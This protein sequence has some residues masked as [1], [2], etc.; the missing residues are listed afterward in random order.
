MTSRSVEQEHFAN[1]MFADQVT[2]YWLAP[3]FLV[4]L[5]LARFLG[6]ACPL[7]P[8]LALLFAF[9]LYNGVLVRL[10]KRRIRWLPDTLVYCTSLLL[11][12]AILAAAIHY[13]G[14]IESILV[15]LTA[16]IAIFSALFLTFAQCLFISLI[17]AASYVAVLAL[18][19]RGTLPHYH[20]FPALPPT[21]HMDG[22]YVVMVGLGVVSVLVTLGLMAGYLATGRRRHS[23]QMNRMHLRLEEWNRDLELRVEEKMRSLRAMH[24]QLQE[25]Y[26]GTVKAFMQALEAKDPYTRS[27]SQAV[28]A[29]AHLIGLELGFSE[30]RLQRLE[31][32][33]E[34]HDIGKIAVPD[35]ILL[36]AGPLTKE[37]FEVVKQHP[38]WGARILESLTFMKDVTE[39]VLQEHERW[40]GRGYP[41]G[42]KGEAIRLEARIIAVTDAW[43]AMTSERPYRGAMTRQAAMA[44]LKGGASTQFDPVIV[45][46]FLRVIEQGKLP[47]VFLHAAAAPA[48]SSRPLEQR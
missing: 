20:I 3:S 11:N 32:G 9:V 36:K 1:W 7:V 27:H 4:T 23:E 29:Y 37:E 42:L 40:D 16:V 13:T 34:L 6:L 38:S 19:Y 24:E 14:G 48:P 15:P 12:T 41:A 28:A 47:D 26:F 39:M 30:E 10:L 44:E 31:Q 46:T 22:P 21:L 2:R 8:S 5:I 25:A 17:A 45:D 35:H 18:E 33:C 43:D